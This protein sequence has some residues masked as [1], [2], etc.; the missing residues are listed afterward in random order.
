MLFQEPEVV[1]RADT[2]G[3]NS[4]AGY[5]KGLTITDITY[6]GQTLHR[7]QPPG[8]NRFSI[9]ELIGMSHGSLQKNLCPNV[10]ESNRIS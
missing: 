7:R 3:I 5:R 4:L 6:I 1:I 9:N 2:L 8:S 10:P